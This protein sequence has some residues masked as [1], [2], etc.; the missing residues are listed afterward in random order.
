MPGDP[1][2]DDRK[3]SVTVQQH[4]GAGEPIDMP[5]LAAVHEFGTAHVPERSFIRRGLDSESNGKIA[6]AYE[7]GVNRVAAGAAAEDVANLMGVVATSAIKS[8]I[9][10]GIP[11]ELA[12]ATKK[13]RDKSKVT[14]KRLKS[15]NSQRTGYT[16]LVDTGQLVGSI[17]YEVHR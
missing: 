15:G 6:K 3:R 10:D 13:R 14:G 1:R 7:V 17:A 16:P 5:T 11:P 8:T 2:K 12:P 9:Y 4:I